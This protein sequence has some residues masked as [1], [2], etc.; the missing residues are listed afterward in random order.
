MNILHKLFTLEPINFLLITKHNIDGHPL[1]AL[2]GHLSRASLDL[3][4]EGDSF[5]K[6]DLLAT[7]GNKNENGGSNPHLHSQLSIK[8]PTKPDMPG[9]VSLRERAAAL[10][11]YPDPQLVLGQLY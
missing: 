1:F 5:S 11:I 6:G 9:V 7:I 10:K 8:E 2:H 4:E 3:R